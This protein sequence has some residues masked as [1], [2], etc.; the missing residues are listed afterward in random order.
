MYKD[1]FKS[2]ATV[3]FEI[4]K[5]INVIPI[6]IYVISLGESQN[7]NEKKIKVQIFLNYLF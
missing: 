6:V 2:L 3:I 7:V 5:L 1:I 4:L